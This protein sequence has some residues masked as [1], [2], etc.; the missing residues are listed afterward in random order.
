MF[1]FFAK[2]VLFFELSTLKI[3]QRSCAQMDSI[4]KPAIFDIQEV[5]GA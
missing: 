5:V 3:G 2:V 4:V 1:F